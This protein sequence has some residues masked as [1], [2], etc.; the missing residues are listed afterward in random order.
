MAHDVLQ[1]L[2]GMH[3]LQLVHSDVKPAN[4]VRVWDPALQ[5]YKYLLIDFGFSFVEGT[6]SEGNWGCSI[7]YASIEML[8][9]NAPVSHTMKSYQSIKCKFNINIIRQ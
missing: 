9:G 2:I 6:A 3:K 8:D 5:R 1:A 7:E 4:I